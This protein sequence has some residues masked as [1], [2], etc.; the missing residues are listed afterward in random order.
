[1]RPQSLK[2]AETILRISFLEE[3]DINTT[4]TSIPENRFWSPTFWLPAL[5][6]SSSS[7]SSFGLPHL[8]YRVLFTFELK[9]TVVLKLKGVY[10]GVLV[11][12]S[13]IRF[14]FPD[15]STIVFVFQDVCIIIFT[16]QEG[17]II[18]FIFQDVSIVGIFRNFRVSNVWMTMY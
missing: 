2:V 17:S 8:E 18:A 16:F 14:I 11:I 5:A 1:M 3:N 12:R 6:C 15:V 9:T 10:D 4:F 7:S 13:I